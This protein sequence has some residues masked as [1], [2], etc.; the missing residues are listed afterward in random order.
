MRLRALASAPARRGNRAVL[1]AVAVAVALAILVP[2]TP[3][4]AAN[5]HSPLTSSAIRAPLSTCSVFTPLCLSYATSTGLLTAALSQI[6]PTQNHLR[7]INHSISGADKV[8][9]TGQNVC[10]APTPSY[11]PTNIC[12]RYVAYEMR[13]VILPTIPPTLGTEVVRSSNEVYVC[14]PRVG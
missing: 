6:T 3:A 12:Y 8:C 10:V 9:S 5:G 4:P 11:I 7:I 2:A 1:A 14:G 13:Y